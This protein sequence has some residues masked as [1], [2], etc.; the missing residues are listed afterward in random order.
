MQKWLVYLFLSSS[1][2]LF[3]CASHVNTYPDNDTYCRYHPHEGIYR[4]YDNPNGPYYTYAYRSHN[5][6]RPY[7]RRYWS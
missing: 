6:Y 2:L 5:P 1:M 4:C 7:P 3:G